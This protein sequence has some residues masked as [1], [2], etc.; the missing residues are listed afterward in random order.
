MFFQKELISSLHNNSGRVAIECES[1]K[2][3]YSGLLKTSDAITTVLLKQGLDNTTTVG[4]FLDDRADLICSVIGILNARCIFVPIDPSLPGERIRAMIKELDLKYLI[5]SRKEAG[6]NEDVIGKVSKLYFEDMMRNGVDDN[7]PGIK[8]PDYQEDDSVYVY[9]TSGSTGVPKGIVGKNNSLLQ[10]LKWEIETFD[11]NS[12]TRVSQFISPYFDAFLRDIFVPLLSGGTIC[13][14]PSGKD[15]LIP[16]VLTRWIDEN[17]ITLIHCVPGFFRIINHDSLKPSNYAQLEYVL[18]SGEKII[19][20]ELLNWYE[21]FGARVQLVNLYGATESTMIR[22]FYLI[23]PKDANLPKIPIGNPISDTALIILDKSMRPCGPLVPGDLY[24]VSDYLTKGYFN[25]PV[26][27][28]EKFVRID[29]GS[30]LSKNAFKTGDRARLLTDGT[31]DLLGREDRMIKLRG[32]RIEIDEIETVLIQSGLLKNAAVMEHRSRNGEASINAFVI[33]NETESS[34]DIKEAAME[35]LERHLPEYMLP[36]AIYEVDE[37]P[38]LSSG[39]INYKELISS[40]KK[41]IIVDPENETERGLMAVWKGV[42]GDMIISTDESFHSMGGN[43]IS[44]MKLIGRIYKEFNVRISLEDIFNNPTIKGQALAIKKLKKDNT[45]IIPKVDKHPFY[46]VSSAQGRVYYNY[47][48]NTSRTSYNL[49]MAWEIKTK[50]DKDKIQEVFRL[51]INRHESL[52]TWFDVEGGKVVQFVMDEVELPMEEYHTTDNGIYNTYTKFIR[53]FDLSKAPLFR[54]ALI[55]TESGRVI[56]LVDFHHIICDGMSQLIL[57][58]DFYKL[59]Y[60]HT[61]EPLAIQYKDYAE[62]EHNYKSTEDYLLHRQFWLQS[63]EGRIPELDLPVINA[64]QNDLSDKG[65]NITFEISRTIL[66]PVLEHALSKEL[67]TGSA[68]FSIYYLFLSQLTGQDDIVIGTAAS[69]RMQQELESV[70]G[71]FVKTLPVRYRL[72]TKMSF[73][74]LLADLHKLLIQALSNQLYDLEDIVNDLN[75]K[76]TV[77]VERLFNAGFV[78]LNFDEEKDMKEEGDFVTYKLLNTGAKNAITLYVMEKA[79]SFYLRLEYSHAYFTKADIELLIAQ[80]K[81]LAIDIAKNVDASIIEIMGNH[82]PAA[83]VTE[84][85]IIFSF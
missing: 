48:L 61:A 10:F 67:T 85:D 64:E 74:S 82:K 65:G 7:T 45:F 47:E 8:Y 54:T 21:L 39:K 41:R 13:I 72:D 25:N 11:V 83:I 68:L 6:V 14:P 26:L 22:A 23:Q 18:L 58:S 63:F 37:F 28:E 69:G 31:I 35:Y 75:N 27:N 55:Y 36:S 15:I 24:I 56:L 17:R 76:K 57:R 30:L 1:R 53:P 49:P 46:N 34:I 9:F 71:M 79:D 38:L 32:I 29:A 51:L 44:I 77:K 40:I 60:G 43:S 5:C 2:I 80:F 84:D 16:S 62:W 70:V 73:A 42:L 20:G 52:R 33:K 59:Y 66:G 19:P 78:F 4:I 12:S 50:P 81:S 3:T